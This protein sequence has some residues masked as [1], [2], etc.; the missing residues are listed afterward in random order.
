MVSN[1]LASSSRCPARSNS[2]SYLE[3]LKARKYLVMQSSHLKFITKVS[4]AFV[5][6]HVS[7]IYQLFFLTLR[8]NIRYLSL[9]RSACSLLGIRLVVDPSWYTD[10]QI[11][12]H[13]SS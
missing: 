4:Y 5:F 11:S 9:L 3:T 7:L 2:S 6:Y 12:N 8:L 10:R 1:Y 13:T